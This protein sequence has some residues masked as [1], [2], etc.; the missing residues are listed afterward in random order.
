MDNRIIATKDKDLC[1]VPG[2]QINWD[3]GEITNSDNWGWINLEGKVSKN[4]QTTYKVRGRGWKYFWAQL[5]MGDTADNIQ[6]LPWC[7]HDDYTGGSAK[8]IGAV[9]TFNILNPITSNADAW[10]VVQKLFKNCAKH[11]P[12]TDYRDGSEVSWKDVLVS[13]MKLLWMRRTEDENDVIDWIK[14]NK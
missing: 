7:V 5:L 8:R 1:M 2:L 12:F 3:S 13:E 10:K 4:K 6:G 11:K 9:L 14:E